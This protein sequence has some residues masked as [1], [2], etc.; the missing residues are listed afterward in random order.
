MRIDSGFGG[1]RARIEMIALI[2]VVFLLLVFFIYAMLSM[3]VFRGLDLELPR[4]RGATQSE[5]IL[6]T[7]DRDNRLIA[8]ERVMD[9]AQIVSWAM[10]R[11]S[12]SGLPVLIRGDREADLGVAVE[13]LSALQEAGLAAVS[14][15][16]EGSPVEDRSESRAGGGGPSD[17]QEGNP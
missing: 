9:P 3:T 8:E 2:D 11:H 7:L 12:Q 10:T 16:V 4:A 15:Q 13:L 17:L 14:F 5:V 1:K 6:V